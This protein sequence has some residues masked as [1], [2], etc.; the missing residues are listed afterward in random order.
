MSFQKTIARRRLN[1]AYRVR[2]AVRGTADRPRV[3]VHRTNLHIYAQM[4]DDLEGRTLCSS[5]SKALELPYGGNLKAAKTVGE[6]LAQKAKALG[7]AKA[8][9]DR[10]ACRY[11]GRIKAVAEALRASGLSL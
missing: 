9:L 11:H 8:C 1:R 4:I 6:D 5:S 7:I 2:K 3:T 10:G